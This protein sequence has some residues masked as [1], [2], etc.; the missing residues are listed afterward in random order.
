MKQSLKYGLI[1]ALAL[2]LHSIGM[3]SVGADSLFVVSDDLSQEGC[4][5]SQG[6]AV[7]GA[8]DHFYFF[9][10]VMPCE[11]GHADV[12]HVPTDKSILRPAIRF[13]RHKEGISHLSD[14]SLHLFLFP[15][16]APVKH[17][18]FGLRKILV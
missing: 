9:R 16:S 1:A 11:I 14:D 12:S 2:L 17:Y 18:V 8:F 5:V 7:H 3:R 6:H 15:P 10:S 13:R 4:F